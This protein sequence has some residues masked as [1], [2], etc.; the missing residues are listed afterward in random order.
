MNYLLDTHVVL[1]AAFDSRRL[2]QQAADILN[3]PHSRLWFSVVSLWEVTIKRALE[4]PDF[5][6]DTSVLW[7]GLLTNGYEE[8][9]VEGRHCLTL[10]TLPGIHSD[11]F[12]RMLVAQAASEGLTLLTA[13]KMVARYPGPVQLI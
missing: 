8:L 11:P 2:P 5:Q 12:D 6:V 3:S 4:R 13:D 7:A 10:S 9:A 1:W